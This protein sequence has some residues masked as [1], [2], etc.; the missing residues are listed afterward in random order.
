MGYA[1][2]L[3]CEVHVID[4]K[5]VPQFCQC[6]L[7]DP[8]LKITDLSAGEIGVDSTWP[9]GMSQFLLPERIL[10]ALSLGF[11][12]MLKLLLW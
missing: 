10:G 5:S 2:V 9:A 4:F 12:A 1:A 7:L 11:E 6:F 3:W 8:T